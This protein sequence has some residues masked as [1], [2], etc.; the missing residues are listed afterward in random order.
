[1]GW[2]SETKKYA[3]GSVCSD[4]CYSTEQGAGWENGDMIFTGPNHMNGMTMPGRDEFHMT[5]KNELRYTY[6]V[7]MNGKWQKVMQEDCKR[8]K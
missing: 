6:Q 1:M 8:A 3:L 5:S 4:G 2:D 7:E